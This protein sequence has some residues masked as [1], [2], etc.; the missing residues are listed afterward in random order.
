MLERQATVRIFYLGFRVVTYSGGILGSCVF[1][2]YDSTISLFLACFL[3]I[4]TAL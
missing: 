4:L 1:M 3:S 2:T